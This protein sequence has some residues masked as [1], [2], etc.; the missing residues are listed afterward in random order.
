MGP[1]G[2]LDATPGGQLKAGCD[3]QTILAE[4]KRGLGE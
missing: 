3:E 1:D 4:I 2:G